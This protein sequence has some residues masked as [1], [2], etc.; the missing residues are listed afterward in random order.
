MKRR[1]NILC[2]LV[3]VVLGYSV[4][5]SMYILGNAFGNAFK[6]GVEMG[7][8]MA[9]KKDKREDIDLMNKSLWMKPIGLIPNSFAGLS[10]SVYNEKSGTYV[11]A[12][13]CQMV[14]TVPT[15]SGLWSSLIMQ[16][17]STFCFFTI[18]LAIILFV[19]LII[20]IN[21]SNIFNWK[22]VYR[23]RWIGGSL[24]LSY[25]CLAIPAFVAGYELSEVFALR[26]YSLHQSELTSITTL[27]LG[28]AS[29]IVAEVF[30]IGLKMKE[31]QDL[32]I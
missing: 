2:V 28:I 8:N 23:I 15:K 1:L 30:A 9:K 6:D 22:N 17:F 29:L 10:D 11:P 13:Y 3:M 4:F 18:L 25:L 12:I 7:V 16:L 19:Q 32:T 31:E 27:V 14:V 20:S 24:I 5:E 21:K 26:G